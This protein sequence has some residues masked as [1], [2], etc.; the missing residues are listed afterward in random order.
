MIKAEGKT[1][2]NIG[3]DI[4][5][6]ILITLMSDIEIHGADKAELSGQSPDHDRQNR[7]MQNWQSPTPDQAAPGENS[8]SRKGDAIAL[9]LQTF[10]KLVKVVTSQIVI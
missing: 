9:L 7:Q 5:V 3:F 10:S 2:R 8:L 6:E 4:P 1:K